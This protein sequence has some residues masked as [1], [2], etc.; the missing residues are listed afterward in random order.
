VGTAG[1]ADYYVAVPA[2]ARHR[3]QQPDW[4]VWLVVD[5]VPDVAVA[6]REAVDVDGYLGRRYQHHVSVAERD[7]QVQGR[8]TDDGL[9]EVDDYVPVPGFDVQVTWHCPASFPLDVAVSG[10][11]PD[12]ILDFPGRCWRWRCAGGGRQVVEEDIEVS[13]RARCE[14]G[15]DPFVEFFGG[16]PSVRGRNLK[17]VHDLVAILV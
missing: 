13:V 10:L 12:R 2:V 15:S 4:T 11:Q 9:G 1:A 6:H 5:A 14:R 16:E 3:D 7:R 17:S 8:L